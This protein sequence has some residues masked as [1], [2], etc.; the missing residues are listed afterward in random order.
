MAAH[1]V[2]MGMGLADSTETYEKV[3]VNLF[4]LSC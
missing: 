4:Y 3:L 2:K 1:Q